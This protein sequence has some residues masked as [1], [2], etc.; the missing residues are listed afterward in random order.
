MTDQSV[1]VDE[2]DR[3]LLEELQRDARLS[4]RA[5]ARIVGMSAGAVGER[6]ERLHQRG[7]IRGYRVE[8]DPAKLGYGLEALIGIQLS[9]HQSVTEAIESL[10]EL[11]E[12][13]QLDLVTGRW[14]LL[15]RVRVRDHDH[16]KQ[17]LTDSVWRV[18]NVQHSE[19]MVVLEHRARPVPLRGLP[20]GPPDGPRPEQAGR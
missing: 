16:L 15:L 8:M 20:S 10:D 1:H 14:D 2:V 11:P 9:Q 4:I 12:V 5:L 13:A 3:R 18:P 6:L 7:V 19:S 17:L